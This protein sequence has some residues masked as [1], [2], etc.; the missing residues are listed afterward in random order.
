MIFKTTIKAVYPQIIAMARAKQKPENAMRVHKVYSQ[1]KEFLVEYENESQKLINRLRVA[2]DECKAK[3][4]YKEGDEFK[5]PIQ[6][7]LDK[8]LEKVQN[9]EIAF[10]IEDKQIADTNKALIESI[11]KVGVEIDAEDIAKMEA[12]A[13]IVVKPN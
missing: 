3:K 8:E 11:K 9:R 4:G 13:N 5:L 2:Q 7:K 12:I 1:I 10:E 6:E